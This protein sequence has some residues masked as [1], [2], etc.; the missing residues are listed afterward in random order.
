MIIRYPTGL[1][2]NQL[3]GPTGK[4]NV[5][6][7]ISNNAPRR[8][9]L[10]FIK[11]PTGIVYRK[12]NEY[13]VDSIERRSTLGSLV[14]T[15]TKSGSSDAGNGDKQYELGQVFDF[16]VISG[17]E[18]TPMLVA[19]TLEMRH[20]TNIIDLNK[21]GLSD[22]EIS[23]VSSATYAAQDD[24][25]VRLNTTRQARADADTLII[26]Y[27][28]TINDA[29]KA[30]D[31]LTLTMDTGAITGSLGTEGAVVETVIAKLKKK[32]DEAFLLRDETI[33]KA[34]KLAA[35]A[36]AL[37]DHLRSIGVLVK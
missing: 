8:S 26:T 21:L 9:E 20:D 31:A 33:V 30:I 13:P 3:P 25:I 5:T 23:A 34:D 2:Y 28:K 1:Y 10:S 14:F 29:T 32:R 24:I 17:K 15:V 18:V 36:T 7:T 22:D 37:A 11:V 12:R 35:E 27:Q 16:D 6:Y 4:G 19:P